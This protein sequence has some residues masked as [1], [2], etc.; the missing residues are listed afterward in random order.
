MLCRPLPLNRAGRRPHIC[1][2]ADHQRY[3]LRLSRLFRPPRARGRRRRAR[4]CR[5]TTR[6]CCSPMPAWCSSR[7]SSPA[8]RSGP[9]SAPPRRRNA[10]APAASTTIW[11]TSATPPGITRFSRCSAI[12]RSATISRSGRSSWPGTWSRASSASPATGCWS[13]SI[14]RMTMRRGCGRRSPACPS[15]RSSAS[16]TSDN[17]WAMGDTGPCGPCSEI[18]YDHGEGIPGGPPGSPDAGRRPLHRD[19]E[20]RLHAVRAA[21]PGERVPLPRAVDRHRH[22][23]RAHRRGAAGQARQLRH[24]PVPRADPGLGRSLG[25]GAGRAARGVAPRHRRSSARLG[26]S[27]RRRR[28]AEQGGARLCAAP[29]HAA[30]DA[31]RPD[32]RLQGSADVAAGAGAGAADG[33]RLSRAAARPAAD[34]RDV[35]ARGE[36]TSS[37]RSSAGLR[38]LEDETAR[39][40]R[41]RRRCPAR[42]PSGSTTPTAFRS[43]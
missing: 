20:P 18:F 3:P 23:A 5:A 17:F 13:R 37:R 26:L 40:G 1:P 30:G 31:P 29:D 34:H 36:P 38:L 6:P 7:T 32:A 15:R 4:W 28:V 14:P 24:R 19:L 33:R 22:G 39:L 10:C 27:D 2:H 9:T 12:S 41:R 11:K 42:S 25:G 8:S 43:T 16:P 35:A 21:G